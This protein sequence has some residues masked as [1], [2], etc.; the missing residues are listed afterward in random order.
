MS[1]KDIS[2][3]LVLKDGVTATLARIAG[4]T[5]RYKK[6]L[7][8]L[9]DQGMDTWKSIKSGVKSA[10]ITV[11]TTTAIASAGL[12]GLGVHANA[13]AETA[14]KSFGIL[15]NS[16]RDAQ[17]MVSDL[18][19]LSRESP[20]EFDGLQDSA[21]MLLGMGYAGQEVMPL[22]YTLGDAV[23]ATGRGIDELKGIALALG[24][25][26]SKGKISAEEMNQLAERGIPA[27]SLLAK[28]MGKS[29]AEVMKLSENGKLFADQALPLIMKGLKD[30]FGGSMKEMSNTFTYTLANIKETAVQMLGELTKP[31]FLAIK[32]DL[33]SIQQMMESSSG[34]KW[35]EDLSNGMVKIYQGA[36][37]VGQSLYTIS[38]FFVNNWSWIEPAVWGVVGAF[39]ALKTTIA[40]LTVKQLALNLAMTAN[41]IGMIIVGIGALIAAGV[42][43][44]RNWDVVSLKLREGWNVMVDAAEWGVNKYVDFANSILRA[45]KFL[46]DSIVWIGKSA[47]NHLIEATESG[48]KRMIKPL[49]AVLSAMGKETVDVSFGGAKFAEVAAPKWDTSFAPIPKV[50]LQ[51]LKANV[52]RSGVRDD[53]EQ[54]R[55][56]QRDMRKAQ[57]ERNRQLEN[58]LNANTA[59]LTNNTSA[60]DKN[61]KARLRDN[62]S[63]MDLAD[64]LLGRIERHIWST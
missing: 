44:W 45:Y 35:A 24:Q 8:E 31:L 48:V 1:A 30:R 39:A 52:H 7:K 3:T 27:W 40:I 34:K 58:A 16:A 55:K 63:P 4:G 43:L 17:T 59:A 49:N 18:R 47:W 38:M 12:I 64:S 13:S 53:L 33:H 5:V 26:K 42:A 50:S 9:K 57:A 51:G 36:K 29:T 28:E 54:A 60:T 10:A 37:A 62:Q 15:L 21:K 6:Q 56:E 22:M 20:F 11:A 46:F 61:T 25:I 2:K 41:P 23:A 19:K 14:E 32:T